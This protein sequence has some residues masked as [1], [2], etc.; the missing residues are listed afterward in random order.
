VPYGGG[1]EGDTS[2]RVIADHVR[3]S[4]FLL[5][6]GLMPSNEGRGYVLRRI[7][8]RASRHA[9]L[10]GSEEPLLFRVLDAVVST[11]GDTYPELIN[12]RERSFRV[13]ESEEERFSR[14]L[15]QG[16]RMLDDLLDSLRSSGGK[17]I[18]GEEVFKLYDTYGFPLDLVRDIAL[19]SGLEIDEAGFHSAMEAQRERA[20]AS[21]VGEEE[22]ISSV[23]RELLQEIGATEFVGYKALE[24]DSTVKAIVQDGK[25]VVEAKEGVEAEVFLDRTPF[26]GESGGQVGDKGALFSEGVR[27]EVVDTRK[28]VEELHSHVVKVKKGPLRVWMKVRARVDGERRRAIMRN[29][30][31]THLLQ[32]ALRTVLGEHVK[33]AGSL[34]GPDGLRFDFT[35]FSAVESDE[36]SSIEEMVNEKIMENLEVRTAVTE[37]DEAVKSGAM[38]LFGEKYDEEVRVVGVSGFSRELCGG[39]HCLFTGEIGPFRISSEGSVAS[40][41]R[42]IEALTGRGALDRIKDERDELEKIGMMLKSPER[43]SERVGLLIEELKESQRKREKARGETMKDMSLEIAQGART[44]DGFKVVSYRVSGLGQKDLRGLAD[45][46]RDRLGSGVVVLASEKE[47]EALLLAMV[48]RDLTDRLSAGK[49]LKEVA[50]RSGG[51]GGGKS[52]MAQGGTKDVER[53]DSALESVYDIV[54]GQKE[55]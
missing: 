37:M 31:A 15:R 47:G 45:N 16:M 26:Y 22:A 6:D 25:V 20:R 19:D 46:V 49:I 2:I 12:E 17:V 35:H 43:P 8:R 50:S 55:S 14:T 7:I 5:S 24:S 13:L 39:T 51:R 32:A 44:L 9:R 33:Q 27:L 34:V 40:G 54:R 41:I 3:A 28:P 10:L 38:A 23:Y 11:M 36:L 29:H 42:R 18:P 21:W 53:L 48:T 30:T 4:A 1:A 52:D